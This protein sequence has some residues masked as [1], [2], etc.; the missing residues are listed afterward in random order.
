MLISVAFVVEGLLL[1]VVGLL[2][3][4][5]RQSR[6]PENEPEAQVQPAPEGADVLPPDEPGAEAAGDVPGPPPAAPPL[7]ARTARPS[8]FE[9]PPRHGASEQDPGPRLPRP[10]VPEH[11][12]TRHPSAPATTPGDAPAWLQHLG[13]WQDGSAPE[14]E[15]E[16]EPSDRGS[17]APAE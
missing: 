4:F 11:Y 5:R 15:P 9:S 16:P 8:W 7:P 12:H 6:A 3:L 10:Y 17:P 13:S 1:L 14:R 2:L